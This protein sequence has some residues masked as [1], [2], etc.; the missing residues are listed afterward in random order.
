MIEKEK[1][2]Q[3]RSQGCEKAWQTN[4]TDESET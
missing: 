4:E 2:E 1:R 3:K